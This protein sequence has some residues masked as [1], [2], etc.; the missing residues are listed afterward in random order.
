MLKKYLKWGAGLDQVKNIRSKKGVYSKKGETLSFSA[1]I[2]CY[3]FHSTTL[4]LHST[5]NRFHR[6]TYELHS[7]WPD[8]VMAG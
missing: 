3:G 8:I 6:T 2:R 7:T 5:T 4:K 1:G